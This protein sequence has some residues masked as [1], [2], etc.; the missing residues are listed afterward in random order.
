[1]HNESGPEG[2]SHS[3]EQDVTLSLQ[4]E[5]SKRA[6]GFLSSVMSAFVGRGSSISQVFFKLSV[7]LTVLNNNIMYRFAK[8]KLEEINHER[9]VILLISDYQMSHTNRLALR[10]L[11]ICFFERLKRLLV[12]SENPN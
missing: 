12:Q 10:E 3:C 6:C 1:M 7:L 4:C 2:Y 9:S 11:K 8:T 5:K